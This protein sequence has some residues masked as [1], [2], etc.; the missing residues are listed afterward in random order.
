M[1]NFAIA[2]TPMIS[3][4]PT[5]VPTN[6][7]LRY[8]V[9]YFY[10]PS[11]YTRKPTPSDSFNFQ[12]LHPS[13]KN[14]ASQGGDPSPDVRRCFRGHLE[15]RQGFMG[16]IV[17]GTGY[18]W[19]FSI[20]KLEEFMTF[21]VGKKSAV[22]F[23]LKGSFFQCFPTK[24]TSLPFT[25]EV[26]WMQ[27]VER[28]FID[29]SSL[30]EVRPK[31]I[32]EIVIRGC[33]KIITSRWFLDILRCTRLKNLKIEFLEDHLLGPSNPDGLQKVSTLHT[34]FHLKL[35]IFHQSPN[36]NPTTL[37]PVVREDDWFFL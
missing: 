18:H 30:V 22:H 3:S 26:G 20:G 6:K 1:G 13:Q 27:M 36:L 16:G 14:W 23:P 35:L 5:M 10:Q 21:V 31:R 9:F 29:G 11:G 2:R 12:H 8:Y 34:N 33:S 7:G 15:C 17:D 32:H 19:D 37:W 24:T 4:V 28:L 25:Q